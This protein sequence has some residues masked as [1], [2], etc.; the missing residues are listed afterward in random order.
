MA[1]SENIPPLNEYNIWS[2]FWWTGHWLK[3]PKLLKIYTFI[4]SLMSSFQGTDSAAAEE[5]K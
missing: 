1:A 5:Q 3:Q 4:T 2:S